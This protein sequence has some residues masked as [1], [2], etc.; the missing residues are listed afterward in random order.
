M[1]DSP[2]E[3]NSSQIYMAGISGQDFPKFQDQD[4][5][6]TLDMADSP[7]LR[8]AAESYPKYKGF[9]I[10]CYKNYCFRTK[11]KDSSRWGWI[12]DWI[13]YRRVR[14]YVACK[15]DQYCLN[16]VK[17]P[18]VPERKPDDFPC[19]AS[20]W[21]EYA[22]YKGRRYGCS[23][24]SGEKYKCC[25]YETLKTPYWDWAID[26]NFGSPFCGCHGGSAAGGCTHV[27]SL[28]IDKLG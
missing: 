2:D 28:W 5:N 27:S 16:Y 24:K 6:N 17:R 19:Y 9:T 7:E 25:W 26:E 20:K 3:E 11:W 22:C 18:P 1:A 10:G 4:F 13:S 21:S 12:E 15:D 14:R 8:L 23:S